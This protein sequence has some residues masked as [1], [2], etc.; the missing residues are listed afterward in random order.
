MI[1]NAGTIINSVKEEADSNRP[2]GLARTFYY[3]DILD[4]PRLKYLDCLTSQVL[5]TRDLISN[6]PLLKKSR[7]ETTL[8]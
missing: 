1:F 2:A 4:D 8:N 3:D 7:N 6:M 5:R